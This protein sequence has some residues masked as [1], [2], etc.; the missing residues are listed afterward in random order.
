MLPLGLAISL[1]FVVAGTVL[2][3]VTLMGE[4]NGTPR[5]FQLSFAAA[6]WTFSL[7]GIVW[8][9][10]A[11]DASYELTLH[12]DGTCEFR[13]LLRRKRVRASSIVSVEL[14]DDMTIVRHHGGRL[15]LLEPDDFSD[16]LA[17][18]HRLSPGL[19]VRGPERWQ[20]PAQSS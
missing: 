20:S 15:H 6:F 4:Y 13:S 5:W 11:L 17:R 9:F 16:F 1:S 19:D 10:G 12:E 8:S 3:V 18:L 7:A 14:D 2:L